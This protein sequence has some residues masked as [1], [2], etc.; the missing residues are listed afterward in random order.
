MRRIV[1]AF[2]TTAALGL[3]FPALAPRIASAGEEQLKESD[4]P[5]PVIDAVK[6]KYPKGKLKSFGKEIEQD[7]SV[8]YE[9]EVE[10]GKR[11]IDVELTPEGKIKCEEETIKPEDAPEKIKKAL[12]AS[13]YGKWQVKH[14]ERV[15]YEEKEEDPS[16]E[17]LVE[18]DTQRFEIVLDKN[19]KITK[20]EEKKKPKA[21]EK[22]DDEKD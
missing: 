1:L 11:Q 14:C 17:Y 16:F 12:A 2:V 22:E 4:V 6:K 9:V 20:E 13:K 5:K 19:G 8:T 21:G 15:V 10:D 3:A 7:K 18:N